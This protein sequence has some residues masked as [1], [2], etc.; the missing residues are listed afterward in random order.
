M[1]FNL[2]SIPRRGLKHLENL[3][4]NLLR[5]LT[6]PSVPLN[7]VSR[8]P[9]NPGVYYAFKGLKIQYIG[10]SRS[11]HKRWNAVGDRCHHRKHQLA[12]MGNVRIHYRLAEVNEIE[13][14]EALEIERFNPPLNVLK[15]LNKIC[16]NLVNPNLKP[17]QTGSTLDQRSG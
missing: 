13:Y 11:L 8:L 15:P 16:S 5:V 1:E 9:R 3:M 10:L 4:I 7:E 17:A 14:L 2:G 6:Y 12:A